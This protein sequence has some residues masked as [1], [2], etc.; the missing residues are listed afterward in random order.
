MPR[1]SPQSNPKPHDH[2]NTR[3][4][5][6]WVAPSAVAA[7]AAAVAAEPY[8][9]ASALR[10]AAAA[11]NDGAAPPGGLHGLAAAEHRCARWRTARCP[12]RVGQANHRQFWCARSPPGKRLD[13]DDKLCNEN[14]KT[15]C[16]T[17]EEIVS[18]AIC[19]SLFLCLKLLFKINSLLS[20]LHQLSFLSFLRKFKPFKQ[21]LK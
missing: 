13:R 1:S 9:A 11:R 8:I 12:A 2:D 21:I 18:F 7:A 16:V 20:R 17:W 15:G 6:R 5:P 19:L 4:W 3:D 10:V 14:K